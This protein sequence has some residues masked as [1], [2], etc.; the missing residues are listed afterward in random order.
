MVVVVV[1]WTVVVQHEFA[2]DPSYDGVP[3]GGRIFGR[4]H[5]DRVQY[6]SIAAQGAKIEKHHLSIYFDSRSRDEPR[7]PKSAMTA[8]PLTAELLLLY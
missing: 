3:V 7:H 4:C 5:V 2:I 6:E 8:R 1:A